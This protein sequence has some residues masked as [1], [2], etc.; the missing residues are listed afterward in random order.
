MIP[1][2]SA[3]FRVHGG[4]FVCEVTIKY[5]KYRKHYSECVWVFL[6][7]TMAVWKYSTMWNSVTVVWRRV[8]IIRDYGGYADGNMWRGAHCCKATTLVDVNLPHNC[9][10]II[11]RLCECEY[12]CALHGEGI[13]CIYNNRVWILLRRLCFDRIVRSEVVSS[14]WQPTKVDQ[15]EPNAT[16]WHFAHIHFVGVSFT[17]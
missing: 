17:S 5:E 6:S 11:G 1:C 12:E 8:S 2:F 9:T 15:E 16:K 14:R 13:R 3:R 7:F 4:G 10:G